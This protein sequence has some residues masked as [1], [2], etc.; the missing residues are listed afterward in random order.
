MIKDVVGIVKAYTT[1]VGEGPFVTELDNEIGEEIRIKGREFGTVTGRSRRCGWFDAVI[2]RYAA[3]VNGLTSISLMLLDVLTG[4]DKIQVCTAYKMGDKII[5]DL[6]DEKNKIL[7]Q[8]Q[9]L[10]SID[11]NTYKPTEKQWHRLMEI[12]SVRCN[13]KITGKLISNIFPDATD[14]QVG[15]NYVFF[16][17]N[18]IKCR[19][20][21]S[22]INEIDIIGN[23]KKDFKEFNDLTVEECQDI[24]D[25]VFQLRT[26]LYSNHF[27]NYL[28][29]NKNKVIKKYKQDEYMKKQL[30]H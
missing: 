29:I 17:L 5:K 28:E 2:V 26:N 12:D 16:K 15:C 19:I 10:T 13:S 30:L 21:T 11:F 23:Y 9:L 6:E 22:A 20:S 14:I 8:Q 3:R 4:F 24:I 25:T 27:I 7:T 18:N 1:R